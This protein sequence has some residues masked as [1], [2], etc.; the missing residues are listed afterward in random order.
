MKIT[1]A[2]LPVAGL[3]TRFLPWTK[4]VPKELLPIGSQ[5]IIA[6]LV[7][8]C[9]S[10]GIDDI[11]FVISR[12]KEM[13]P[14]FFYAAPQLEHELKK[15]GKHT[16]IDEIK[17][18]DTVRLHVVYQ[19][20]QLGDGHAILQAAPWVNSDVIAVLFGDDLIV[21]E[22]NGLQQLVKAYKSLPEGKRGNASMLMLENI[23]RSLTHKY[24]IADID[25]TTSGSRL[26]KIRGLVEKPKSADAPSTLGVVGKYLIPRRIFDLLPAVEASHGGEI[27]LVDGLIEHLK[28]GAVYG[29]EFEG[30]RYDTGSP[31][32]YKNAVQELG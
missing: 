3:G 21:G 20:E 23:P 17:R 32:G 15:R 26:K 14:Q 13:I 8:E 12:G 11:C 28:D 18:Y 27:R 10:V 25:P 2:I 1:Q 16:M 6:H 5:P 24:G 4:V 29:Y 7:D 22:E 19:E 31:E 30:K 9:L